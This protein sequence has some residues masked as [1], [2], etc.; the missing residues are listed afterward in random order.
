MILASYCPQDGLG[1]EQESCSG[2]IDTTKFIKQ[3]ELSDS[4]MHLNRDYNYLLNVDR[5]IHLSK[6]DIK[7]KARNIL[8]RPRQDNRQDRKRFKHNEAEN[9]KRR[10]RIGQVFPHDPTA[11]VKRENTM[12]VQVPPGMQR[13]MLN[14]T[15]YD[16]KS[17]TFTWTVE[18]ILMDSSGHTQLTTF[19]S[20][21]L[22][23]SLTLDKA[24]PLNVL[25]SHGLNE[26]DKL[27]FYLKNVT[28]TPPKSVIELDGKQSI[29]NALKDKIVLEYPTIYVTSNKEAMVDRVVDP[30]QAYEMESVESDSSDSDSDSSSSSESSSDEESSDDD[31]DSENDSDSGPEES[32]TKPT[33]SSNK[34]YSSS[35]SEKVGDIAG[36]T[37]DNL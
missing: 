14:K 13:A 25:K 31:S 5:S 37:K 28:N 15:G 8:K 26:I 27:H 7:Q 35:G 30:C 1:F 22:N 16:R 11:L 18:W 10:I 24:V 23:E 32:T 21:R 9:D 29:S 34:V 6:E 17:N 36:L 33:S 3:S 12:I 19:L 4:P 2:K 20:Y